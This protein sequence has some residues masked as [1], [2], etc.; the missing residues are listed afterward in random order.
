MSYHMATYTHVADTQIKG[1]W[2]VET[3]LLQGLPALTFAI[4][5]VSLKFAFLG[6]L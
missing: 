4:L 1:S 5:L 3:K 6:E 2:T